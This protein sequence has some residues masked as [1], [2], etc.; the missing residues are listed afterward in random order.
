MRREGHADLMHLQNGLLVILIISGGNDLR[1]HK[2]FQTP[3][4]FLS[5]YLFPAMF[6]SKQIQV[7]TS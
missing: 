5:G 6:L 7:T 2:H 4:D 1:K 3:N